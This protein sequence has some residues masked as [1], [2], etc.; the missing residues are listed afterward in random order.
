MSDNVYINSLQL[1]TGNINCNIPSF[2]IQKSFN[3]AVHE[4]YGIIHP[5]TYPVSGGPEKYD[6]ELVLWGRGNIYD[7]LLD[8]E[9]EIYDEV[10]AQVLQHNPVRISTDNTYIYLLNKQVLLLFEDSD[11]SRRGTDGKNFISIKLSG[12]V[13]QVIDDDIVLVAGDLN[14]IAARQVAGFMVGHG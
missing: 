2:T 14:G 5:V 10:N 3:N 6:I 9:R 13:C 7:E 8:K 12:I 11:F 1:N 4:Q